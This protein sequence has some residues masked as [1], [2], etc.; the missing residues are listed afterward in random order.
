VE[1]LPSSRPL[2]KCN[3]QQEVFPLALAVLGR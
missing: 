3:P 2:E 1:R